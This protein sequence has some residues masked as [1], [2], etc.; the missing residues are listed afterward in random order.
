MTYFLVGSGR[1]D[2][3]RIRPPHT[4]RLHFCQKLPVILFGI[5]E[6][7]F[8]P[9]HVPPIENRGA[10]VNFNLLHP[11]TNQE[12]RCGNFIN[13]EARCGNSTYQEATPRD[14]SSNQ[15]PRRGISTNQETM[16]GRRRYHSGKEGSVWT[17]GRYWLFTVVIQS[18]DDLKMVLYRRN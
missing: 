6:T 1:F 15:E 16:S 4:C 18:V 13:Q 2:Q 11:S 9:S 8:V 7:W 17:P 10:R 14:L 3:I 5:L 12:A